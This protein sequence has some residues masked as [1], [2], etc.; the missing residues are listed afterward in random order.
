[1]AEMT[2]EKIASQEEAAERTEE[3]RRRIEYYLRLRY[4]F[5]ACDVDTWLD[6]LYNQQKMVYKAKKDPSWNQV[7][8]AAGIGFW[9]NVFAF[10]SKDKKKEIEKKKEVVRKE[11]QEEVDKV[12]EAE[13]KR[14]SAYN[15]SLHERLKAKL[16]R[17]T[18]YDPDE[19]K[20]YFSFALN[21][22]TFVLE[23]NYYHFDYNLVYDPDIKQLIIDCKLPSIDDISRNK[24]W[25]ADKN[26]EVVPKEMNKT[27][28]LEMYERI[29]F[30]ISLR[31]VGILFESD[32]NHVLHSIVFNGS[33]IY[34]N[35]Q[36]RPTVI[37]SFKI[38]NSQ[39]SYSRIRRM[40]CIS[41]SEIAKLKDVRYLADITT[42]KPPS[43]LWET[44]P[45]K[46]VTPIRSS[47]D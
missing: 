7:R 4:D 28:F 31:V 36:E 2:P 22:D 38:L 44:P 13:S 21:R 12:N 39:Y 23:G 15:A 32:T 29:L 33:C 34:N 17:L 5:C 27:D 18:S 46:L 35:W 19:I 26:N 40:D 1:M 25:K 42:E 8:K 9:E 14:C 3:E 37:I 6:T 16:N 20:E 43:D 10:F 11:L 30:D 47:W 24:E 41:K 45:S